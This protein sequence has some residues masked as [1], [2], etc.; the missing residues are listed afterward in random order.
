MSK[1]NI[2]V[3]DFS[4][5]SF[6]GAKKIENQVFDYDRNLIGKAEDCVLVSWWARHC[7]DCD[8]EQLFRVILKE[9]LE[10]FNPN[11]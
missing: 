10:S 4:F 6:A 11:D 9:D 3:E 1:P 5:I 8:V 2:K 7:E